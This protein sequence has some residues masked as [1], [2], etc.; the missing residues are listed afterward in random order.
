MHKHQ[1]AALYVILG[2]VQDVPGGG[3]LQGQVAIAGWCD[4]ELQA[5]GRS[6]QVFCTELINCDF[7]H[8]THPHLRN[9]EGRLRAFNGVVTD[10]NQLTHLC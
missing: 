7:C 4:D 2:K 3:A 6:V 9:R 5:I 8:R 10:Y 1:L